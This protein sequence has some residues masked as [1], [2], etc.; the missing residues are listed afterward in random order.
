MDEKER[1]K[2]IALVREKE[3]RRLAGT[4]QQKEQEEENGRKAIAAMLLFLVF[5]EVIA[6]VTR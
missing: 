1:Q 4:T 5:A 2:K 6:Y 3:Y